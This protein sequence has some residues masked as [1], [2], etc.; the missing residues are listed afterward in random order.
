[1][2]DM[3]DG[4]KCPFPG[5]IY[6]PTTGDV[7]VIQ[8]WMNLNTGKMVQPRGT[9]ACPPRKV[10]YLAPTDGCVCEAPFVPDGMG[11][12]SCEPTTGRIPIVSAISGLEECVC[13]QLQVFDTAANQCICRGH[14]VVDKNGDC[15]CPAY[16]PENDQGVFAC[17]IPTMICKGVNKL[18]GA[19]GSCVCPL[20]FVF[21]GSGGCNACDNPTTIKLGAVLHHYAVIPLPLIEVVSAMHVLTQTMIQLGV[22][23]HHYAVIPLPLMEVVSAMPVLTLSMIQPRAV[24]HHHAVIPLH[25]MDVG[26]QP[27]C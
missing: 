11:G 21:D 19:I 22:V 5:E 9:C 4:C 17:S 3:V 7:P 27:L 24:L 12:C 14:R 25:V 13:P 23:L 15:T 20:L 6:E 10:L 1:M 16:R 26:L 8:P 2:P 18:Y